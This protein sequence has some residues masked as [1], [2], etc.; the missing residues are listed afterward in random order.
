LRVL[1]S[2]DG[3][4]KPGFLGGQNLT[5]GLDHREEIFSEL[6]GVVGA[7]LQLL[8][9]VEELLEVVER[10]FADLSSVFKTFLRNLRL[11]RAVWY[12]VRIILLLFRAVWYNVRIILLLFRAV[13]YGVRII[14]LLFLAV[15]YGVRSTFALIGEEQV[16]DAVVLAVG[17]LLHKIVLQAGINVDYL[18]GLLLEC[19]K[20]RNLA[21]RCLD[22]SGQLL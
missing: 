22:D 14:L 19:E 15:W 12:G 13:W 18:N 16:L 9:V 3:F 20:E 7:S 17:T 2:C 8:A 6:E 5:T 11:F 21:S 1:V 4:D 10:D